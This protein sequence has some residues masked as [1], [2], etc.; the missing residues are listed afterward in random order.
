M[1]LQEQQ[2]EEKKERQ[3]YRK[4]LRVGEGTYGTVYKAYDNHLKQIV[5]LKKIRLE[6]ESDGI[7]ASTLREIC[8]LKSINHPNI[9]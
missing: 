6:C 2:E 5:A 9:V 3:R 8:L 1:I 7:P 4:I